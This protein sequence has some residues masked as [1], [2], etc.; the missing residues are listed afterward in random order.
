MALPHVQIIPSGQISDVCL[1]FNCGVAAGGRPA[2]VPTPEKPHLQVLV[3][4]QRSRLL[5][6]SDKSEAQTENRA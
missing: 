5:N 6:W 1:G 4:G 2:A 3:G